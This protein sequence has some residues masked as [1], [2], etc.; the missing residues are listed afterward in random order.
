MKIKLAVFDFDGTLVSSHKTIYKAM[1]RA[2]RELNINAEIP[3][4]EFYNLIGL[5]L[6]DLFKKFGFSV[7][8]FNQ[9]ISLYKS[10]YFDY[11][12]MSFIYPGAAETLDLLKQK[13]LKM[14]L[15][16]TK[17]QDQAELNLSY[18]KLSDKF[19][20]VMGRRPEFAN[21]PSPEP[22]LKI[23]KDLEIDISDTIMIGDTELDIYCGKNAGAKTCAV[24]YGYR[25]K[26]ELIKTNPDYLIDKIDDLLN[27][28]DYSIHE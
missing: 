3:E 11:A 18:F 24:T 22:L 14:A 15:L 10:I 9:F 25:S 13:R 20:Y 23:C 19:D 17:A 5:H 26:E 16:T 21:K 6:E 7:P 4:K 28:L 27:I 12:D 8:D 2:L 1:I